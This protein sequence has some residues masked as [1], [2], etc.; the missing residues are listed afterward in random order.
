MRTKGCI[1]A[2]EEKG[3]TVDYLDISPQT[4]ADPPAGI[5]VIVAY[6]ASHPDVDLVITDHGG[7]TAT[8]QTY[9]EAAGKDPEEI[10]V[11]G[12]DLSSA[13]VQAIRS[14]YVQVVSDQQPWLQA[15]LAVF[16]LALAKQFGF[17][18]LYIDTGAGFITK[19]NIDAVAALAEAGIR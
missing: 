4:N 17:S 3:V 5:P 18:G 2:L 16:Q 12:F 19:D 7:L 11:A 8:A 6:I 14:G 1:D 10:L 9:M 15:F 13:T